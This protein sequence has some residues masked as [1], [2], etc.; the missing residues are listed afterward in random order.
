M[1]G[2][3]QPNTFFSTSRASINV[4]SDLTTEPIMKSVFGVTGAFLPFSRTPKPRA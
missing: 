2:V 3:S 4:V 1:I